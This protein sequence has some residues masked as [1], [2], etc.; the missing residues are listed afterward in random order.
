[1]NVKLSDRLVAALKREYPFLGDSPAQTGAMVEEILFRWLT[2]CRTTRRQIDEH[3]SVVPPV[4]SNR[5]TFQS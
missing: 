3:R 1:M 5:P 4:T 2:Q